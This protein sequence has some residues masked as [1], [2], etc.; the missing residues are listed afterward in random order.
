[1]VSKIFAL[2]KTSILSTYCEQMFQFL[3]YHKL[4]KIT[5]KNK[6]NKN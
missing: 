5:V 1:M 4:F 3:T 2:Y 6:L